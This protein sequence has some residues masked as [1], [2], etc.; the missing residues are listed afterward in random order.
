MGEDNDYW[1]H[2]RPKSGIGYQEF[3]IGVMAKLPA[4]MNYASWVAIVE[5]TGTVLEYDYDFTFNRITDELKVRKI[6]A[7]CDGCQDGSLNMG[8]I[9]DVRGD[10]TLLS[11]VCRPTIHGEPF[12]ENPYLLSPR[13]F[14]EIGR[15]NEVLIRRT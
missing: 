15:N 7:F 9:T 5:P 6:L 4:V 1:V 3:P 2:T 8:Y 11:P 12:T 13:M 10:G 14:F